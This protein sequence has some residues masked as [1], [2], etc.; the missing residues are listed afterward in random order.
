MNKL[1]WHV[2]HLLKWKL[3][4]REGID[5]RITLCGRRNHIVHRIRVDNPDRRG[6]K[7]RRK[8]EDRRHKWLGIL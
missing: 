1:L 3:D 5:R 8:V 4:F 2:Q 7:E 6:Y